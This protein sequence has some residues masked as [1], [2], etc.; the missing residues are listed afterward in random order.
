MPSIAE[1]VQA[2]SLQADLLDASYNVE[3]APIVESMV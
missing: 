3:S 1:E 2:F